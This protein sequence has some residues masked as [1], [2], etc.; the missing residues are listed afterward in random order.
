[1][2]LRRRRSRSRASISKDKMGA[3]L[4]PVIVALVAEAASP[5]AHDAGR[6]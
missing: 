3:A 5:P 4:A 1:V 6:R 2:G